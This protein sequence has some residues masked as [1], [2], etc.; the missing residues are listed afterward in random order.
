MAPPAFDRAG[1][2]G[3]G[4]IGGSLALDLK[5]HGLT[6]CVIGA[7]LCSE[8]LHAA[9]RRGLVDETSDA[10]TLARTCDLVVLCTPPATV[11]ALARRLA[12]MLRAGSVL[13]DV[14]SVKAPVARALAG[15]LAPGH[16]VVPGHPVAGTEHSGPM[17]AR[18][19]L[20]AGRW[21]LLTPLD[22]VAPDATARVRALWEAVGARVAE[23]APDTHD[24]L[25]ATVSH[26]PHAVAWALVH[27]VCHHAPD[28]LPYAAGGLADYTRIARSD[29]EMWRD[30]F[31]LNR[32]ALL[33]AIDAMAAALAELRALVGGDAGGDGSGALTAWIEQARAR[34]VHA[35][36]EATQ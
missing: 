34:H 31:T 23:M 29:P 11:G 12:P 5:A 6:Q 22:G 21:C 2:V 17:A 1:I 15:A 19:G 28:A 14:A 27:A 8:H 16:R 33:P 13:T 24:R 25:M 36:T 7:D 32:E 20:F 30:V 35:L 4:L 26:L 10:E 3:V 9:R 18:P